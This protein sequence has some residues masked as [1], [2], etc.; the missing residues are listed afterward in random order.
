MNTVQKKM[1]V[2]LM[3]TM[4]IVIKKKLQL[5]VQI[6]I[7]FLRLVVQIKISFLWLAVQIKIS[8]L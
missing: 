8:F 5:A 6:E 1:L 3:H 2:D 4:Q 7:S